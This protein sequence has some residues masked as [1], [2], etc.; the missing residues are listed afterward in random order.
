MW[1]YTSFRQLCNYLL[2]IIY[3]IWIED[4][5]VVVQ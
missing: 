3:E 2:I 1:Y 4:V 5:F